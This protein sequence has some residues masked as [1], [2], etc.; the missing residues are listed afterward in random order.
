MIMVISNLCVHEQ[1]N[2]VAALA[3]EKGRLSMVREVVTRCIANNEY[4]ATMIQEFEL[5]ED[6]ASVI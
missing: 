5:R 4:P 1:G 3:D 6:P 2:T